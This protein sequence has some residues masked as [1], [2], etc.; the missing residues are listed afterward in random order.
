MS[1][2][3]TQ[4]NI[5]SL[6]GDTD[7]KIPIENNKLIIVANN[8]VGKTTI[9]NIIYYTLSRQWH[10]LAHYKFSSISFEIDGTLYQF[11]IGDLEQFIKYR[12]LLSSVR[13]HSNSS[14]NSILDFIST[15]HDIGQLL[16]D[17]ASMRN[18]ANKFRI[19]PSYLNEILGDIRMRNV[20]SDQPNNIQH[21]QTAL[22][23]HLK[24]CQILYLPTYRRIEKDLK[25]IFPELEEELET[26]RNRSHNNENSERYVELVEFGMSDVKKQVEKKLSELYIGFTNNVRQSLMGSYLKDVLNKAFLNIDYTFMSQITTEKIG[27]ILNRID[28]SIMQKREKQLLANFVEKYKSAPTEMNNEE[29]IIAYFIQKMVDIFNKQS[30][31]EKDVVSFV[32]LCNSYCKNKNFRYSRDE[33]KIRVHLI[34]QEKEIEYSD[35]SSGE[36]Q[37]VSLFS[38]LYLSDI[39]NFFVIIDEPELSLSVSWQESLLPDILSAYNAGLIAV[40]HSPFIFNNSLKTSTKS[41]NEFLTSNRME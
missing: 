1:F 26:F 40:T 24:S 5:V 28:D 27:E 39:K 19:S 7:V 25:N 37:I 33:G 17:P 23:T 4:F 9:V 34:E 10:K 36:K 11:E 8:G 16:N 3:L 6:N 22:N 38:H 31:Q 18:V 20:T 2:Q 29:R 21:I 12:K 41:A 35:L 32:D 13:R 14:A 15:H 30:E